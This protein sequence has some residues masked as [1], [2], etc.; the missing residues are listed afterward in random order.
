MSE[1]K[2]LFISYSWQTKE[3]ADKIASD[4]SMS[5]ITVIKDNQELGY[6]NSITDFMKRIR[7]SDYALLLISDF[8][9][10]SKNC[11]YEVLELIKDDNYWNK[12]LPIVLEETKIYSALDRLH[13]IKFW[14]EKSNELESALTNVKPIN[15]IELFKEL[16]L[17]Q[18]ISFNI[19]I[20]IKKVVDSIHLTPTELIEKKYKPIIDKLGLEI[21]T[22]PLIKLLDIALIQDLEKREIALDDFIESNKESAYY[23]SVKGSTAR[24]LRKF[25]QAIHFYKKGLK[26]D[27]NNFAILN[28]YGQVVEHYS[29]NYKE[30]KRLYE[31]AIKSNP[32]S[33][34]ARLN[35]GVLLRHHFNNP[36]GAK[37]Q[38]L[39]V[40]EFNPDSYKA[41]NNISN[42]YK[43]VNPDEEQL[44]KI[45][46]H[47]KKAIEINPEY[48]EALINYGNFL[49]VYRKKINEGNEYYLKVRKLDKEGNLNSLLNVLENSIKG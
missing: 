5:L 34:I 49:K 36:Q 25:E 13:Y 4:L 35:L 44:Q 31:R 46:F 23:F 15:S 45:E 10:K 26:I 24:D 11:L 1:Q 32:H 18:D 48:I 38:Y 22:E 8:Y 33:E 41:H 43:V 3:I 29:K 14:E 27:P 9:L 21:D 30:A 39:K 28:N 20:F 42:I 40:L 7:T 16:K 17:F 12:V 19:D 37:K 47:L 2:T 6:T